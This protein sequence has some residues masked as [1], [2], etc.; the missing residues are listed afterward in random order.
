MGDQP[1]ARLISTQDS[2]NNR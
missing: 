2:T 1:I